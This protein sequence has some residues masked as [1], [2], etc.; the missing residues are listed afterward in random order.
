MGGDSRAVWRSA[1]LFGAIVVDSGCA[2]VQDALGPTRTVAR[3]AP[4]SDSP[5]GAIHLA[6]HDAPQSPGASRVVNAVGSSEQP[7]PANALPVPPAPVVGSRSPADDSTADGRVFPI[8]LS[9]ALEMTGGQNPEVAFAQARIRESL[10]RLEQAEVLWLPS[11]RGGLNYNKHDGRIQEVA[12][13]IID[14]S[15]NAFYT[16]FGANAVGAASPVYPGLYANFHLTDAVFQPRIA[17]ESA[18][19]QR[20]E[21]QSVTNDALLQTAIAYLELLRAGQEMA[22]ARETVDN[23]RKLADLT[24]S[25]A[26]TG[27]GLASDYDRARTE[28][29]L[30][31]NDVLRAQE[32][33]AVA[34]ARLARQLHLDPSCRLEP[35]EPAAAPIDLVDPQR[36][37]ADVVAEGLSRRPETSE[38]RHLVCE[39]VERLRREQYAPLIPS[40]LL[41][42]SYGGFGGGVGGG[43]NNFGSR[44]D[45]DA[46]AFWE[47]RNLGFGERAARSQA[48]ARIE[49]ARMRELAILDRVAAEIVEAHAQVESRRRQIEVAREATTSAL[50]SYRRNLDRIQNAQGLPIEVLQSIQALAAARREYLRAVMDHNQAQF[51]LQRAI[52]WPTGSPGS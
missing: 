41:G 46:V 5:R 8:D 34:S 12:G 50:S 22:I 3:E 1:L 35:F 16:G 23:S 4:Q 9:T 2:A 20:W 7:Q 14:T 30:R 36:G 39:A 38:N 17:A 49:Q 13:N 15:R 45:A 31:N 27:E 19:A 24:G 21:A 42:V 33:A 43:V 11:L 25:Y 18:T 10:A 29:S 37:V 52:G 26:R 6:S 28:L 40:V 48:G 32:A 47:L 51:Q 44:F